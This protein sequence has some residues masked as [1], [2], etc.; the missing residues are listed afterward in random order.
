M[1]GKNIE[2]QRGKFTL[3][4]LLVVISIIAILAALLLPALNA[5]R[6][7]AYAVSCLNNQRQTIL[8][9]LSYAGDHNSMYP[10]KTYATVSPWSADPGWCNSIFRQKYMAANYDIVL[11][12]SF[13]P[14]GSGSVKMSVL[15]DMS[16]CKVSY[17]IIRDINGILPYQLACDSTQYWLMLN[18]RMMKKPSGTVIAGDSYQ[19]PSASWGTK[20][21]QVDVIWLSRTNE[22]HANAHARHN[23]VMN[24]MFADGHAS[25][26]D[27]KAYSM[28]F[29]NGDAKYTGTVRYYPKNPPA[30]PVPI[31]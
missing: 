2:A 18:F 13:P 24:M 4:E 15:K 21:A 20:G 26:L 28:T 1:N 9:V 10:Y 27:P 17:G 25:A 29:P 23:R 6:E 30:I 11:C 14:D 8:A 31:N 22:G 7:K 16:G 19:G 3:I 12:P 5:A